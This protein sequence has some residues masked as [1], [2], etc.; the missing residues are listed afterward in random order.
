MK[1]T[2]FLAALLACCVNGASAAVTYSGDAFS[3]AF[4]D[5][6]NGVVY[7]GN[8]FFAVKSTSGTTVDL[9]INLDSLYNYAQGHDY[10]QSYM[11][12][13]KSNFADYGLADARTQ[14]A[15]SGTYT[16]SIT[17]W[18]GGKA[19]NDVTPVSYSTLSRYADAENNVT[20]T[21][22]NSSRDGV[23]VSI[24]NASVYSA[25]GLKY[26]S[27]TETQ[28]YYVNLNYV[29]G[30]TLHTASTLDV[31]SYEIPPNYTSPFESQRTDGTSIGRTMFLG[32]S[33][34]HGYGNQSHRWQLFKTLVDSGIENEIVG[35]RSG[36]HSN[37]NGLDDRDKNSNSYGGAEFNNV[38]L[39]QSSGRTHNIISG[40]VSYTVNGVAYGSGVNY[41][42]HSTASAGRNYDCD[43]FVC[44]MGTNDLLSDIGSNAAPSAYTAQMQKMLG[45]TVSLD[46]ATNTWSWK[47][48]TNHLG[49]MGIIVSD[50]VNS[51][52]DTFYVMSVPTWGTKN[53][54]HGED[55]TC[56]A[57][58]AQYNALLKQWVNHWNTDTSG[59]TPGKLVY[60]D[61]NRGL[62]D[63]TAGKFIGPDVFMNAAD[64]LH[65]TEQG[66]LIIA[67][68]LAQGMGIGGR[69]AGL[70]RQGTAD[71]NSAIVGTIN[72]GARATLV[73]ENAFTMDNGYTVDFSAAFGNGETGGW[74]SAENALSISLGDGT[75][76]GT[77]NLSEGYIM[78]GNDILYCADTSALS[79]TADLPHTAANNNLRIAWHNG[80]A[81]ENVLQ[82]YYVWLGDMLIG[83]GLS[84]TEGQ[85]LN[86]ILFSASGADGSIS[87]LSWT[88]T[89][90]APTTLGKYSAEYAYI[91]TQDTAAVS[92][93][94]ENTYTN[95]PS[96]PADERINADAAVSSNVSYAGITGQAVAAMSHLVT[97]S[98]SADSSFVIT[99][100]PDWIGLTNSNPTGAVNA[101]LVGTAENAI[102]GVMN[103]ADAGE[104]T[105]EI[106]EGA[107]IRGTGKNYSPST[108]VAIAGSYAARGEHAK[109]VSF[110]VY[111]NGGTVNG[112]IIGG[113]ASGASTITQVNLNINSGTVNGSVYGGSMGAPSGVGSVNIRVSG[114]TISGD[115]VAGG[116]T[117]GTVDN[118]EV[119]ISGG[120]IK[121]DIIKGAAA[122]S[123][124]TIDG[125][126][127][128]VGGDIEADKVTLKNVSS[129]GYAD[130]FDRY[131][132]TVN[133]PVVVLD[134]V[135]CK[136]MAT[137][138][139]L[140]ALS[141]VNGTHTELTMDDSLSLRSLEL[142]A[143]S[144]LGIFRGSDHTVSTETETVVTV[145]DTL[146]VRGAGA[147]LN[148]NLVVA[149]GATL[150]FGGN[151]LQLGSS[152]TL[153]G[154]SLDDETMSLVTNLAAGSSLTLFTGVDE[155][156]IGGDSW[157]GAMSTDASA[158]FS[159]TELSGYR[160]V[161]EGASSGRVRITTAAVPEPASSLLGLA[162]LVAFTL[163]RRR[164][165]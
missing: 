7:D 113:A 129:S 161:Y 10:L 9:T 81:A 45:G 12:Q 56:R 151:S 160:L 34:T 114:G 121:G 77:L 98:T 6:E 145:T 104:I 80:N 46:S 148:A 131:G 115:I 110:N 130:T 143:D 33:I 88:D 89:S 163:R 100:T 135:Q 108:D 139:G 153:G 96:M 94:V 49:T 69:T 136:I 128:Y 106:E 75:N 150:N 137:L 51:D 156:I 79:G 154:A 157:T 15:D 53:R 74:L 35:P 99:S 16:P 25:S 30:I 41:G 42:G 58:A 65:P 22:T 43:T 159:N 72:A 158:A 18:A 95:L 63:V 138:K 55:D 57:A 82:G 102:F 73:G 24:G 93:M 117:G 116:L 141:A 13:Y 112:N 8:G 165:R 149:E 155:L 60:V 142:G 70:E 123:S 83:Q 59:S 67:G 32:D 26:S 52:N 120:I 23:S 133:A 86:G 17:G 164:C 124:V 39:A 14:N 44:M 11:L 36:Y 4:R 126:K 91:T 66:S 27:H 47:A 97:S 54:V 105:L 19:W 68:N 76:S 111:L 119:T 147:V 85:G 162:G 31:N 127:A 2:L 101:Q 107:V 140:E 21:I 78:W 64:G 1:K 103:N 48:D 38:H 29:T 152:L 122:S 28:G 92:G 37:L 71:W 84:A 5:A 125:N 134:N 146:L 50:V 87:G 20:L 109:A 62:V 3:T 90:Y 132:G 40:S 144:S 61:V 118:A